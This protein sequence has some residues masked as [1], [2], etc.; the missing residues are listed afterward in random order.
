METTPFDFIAD[1]CNFVSKFIAI[2]L[3][4]YFKTRNENRKD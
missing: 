3:Y 1:K 2:M 4:E